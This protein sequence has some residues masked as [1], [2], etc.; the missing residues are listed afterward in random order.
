VASSKSSWRLDLCEICDAF[1]RFDGVD[2]S[3]RAGTVD[4]V[5]LEIL[6]AQFGSGVSD[7]VKR[8]LELLKDPKNQKAHQLFNSRAWDSVQSN[9]SVGLCK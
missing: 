7:T 9:F 2:L 4:Q 8:T 5:V 1:H 6:Q 3:G